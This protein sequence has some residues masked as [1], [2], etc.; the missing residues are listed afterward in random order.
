[1]D[2][3]QIKNKNANAL[4]LFL[5]SKLIKS[6]NAVRTA[7]KQNSLSI[8]NNKVSDIN[9]VP[10]DYLFGEYLLLKHGKKSVRLLKL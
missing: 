2:I 10:T 9:F 5:T 3:I 4:E 7:I 8:N 6:N 1:M